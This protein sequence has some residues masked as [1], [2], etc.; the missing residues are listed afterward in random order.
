MSIRHLGSDLVRS[1]SL[2]KVP[3]S[4][5]REVVVNDDLGTWDLEEPIDQMP[6][7]ESCASGDEG[8]ADVVIPS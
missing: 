1:P 8:Y 3:C 5:W 6:A 2:G 7:D 4:T